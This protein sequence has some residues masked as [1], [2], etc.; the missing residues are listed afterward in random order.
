[1]ETRTEIHHNEDIQIT[2][3]TAVNVHVKDKSAECILKMNLKRTVLS[4]LK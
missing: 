4:T 3:G 2:V 1:M